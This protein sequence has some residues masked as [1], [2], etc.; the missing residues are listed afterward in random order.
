M[1]KLLIALLCVT[2]MAM[3]CR[4]LTST[5]YIKP[6][7]SFVLGQGK[8]GGYTINL[9]NKSRQEVTIRQIALDG[10]LISSTVANPKQSLSVDVP[11]NTTLQIV[12][13][14]DKQAQVALKLIG[15]TNLSMG[16]EGGYQ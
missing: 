5:T 9:K 4:S 8:H 15:D 7:Q 13:A 12:N 10:A 6:R 2:T 3:S 14:S 11:K 1:Q 16:Y